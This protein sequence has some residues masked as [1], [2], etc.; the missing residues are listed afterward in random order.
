MFFT[1]GS[2][3]NENKALILGDDARH[4]ARS[5]RMAVGDRITVSDGKGAVYLCRLDVIRD[6]RCECSIIEG[7]AGTSESPVDITLFMAFPKGDKMETVIQK[8]VEL[9]VSRIVPF[10]S[11]RCVKIPKSEKLDRV[12]ERYNRIATE[13][14]KQCGRA[15]LPAVEAPTTVSR[16]KDRVSEFDLPLF[17]YEGEGTVSLKSALEKDGVKTVCAVVGCE[18]GFSDGEA[19]ELIEAGFI[20]VNLGPRI[21]R[22]ETAPSYVLSAI[23]YKFE[24]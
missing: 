7:G 3:I 2:L 24:L 21:L 15:L 6:E 20:P 18:G 9:G 4:I 1:D 5:L 14:A 12:L 8:S 23:S 22:C 17:C 11:E 10:E 19:R 13:A 16:L